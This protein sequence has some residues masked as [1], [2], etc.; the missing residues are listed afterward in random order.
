MPSTG[1]VAACCPIWRYV[2]PEAALADLV[3]VQLGA[4]GPVT[5][6]DLAYFFGV[7]LS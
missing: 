3:L 5:R 4:Y 6:A 7:S 2:P 1:P